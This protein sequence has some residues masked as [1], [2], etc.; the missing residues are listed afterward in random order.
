[1]QPGHRW[2]RLAAAY[3]PDTVGSRCAVMRRATF[4]A[5][6]QQGLGT[7]SGELS[8][9]LRAAALPTWPTWRSRCRWSP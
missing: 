9:W 3:G 1:M 8:L 6:G 7:R 4:E 5:A 2:L